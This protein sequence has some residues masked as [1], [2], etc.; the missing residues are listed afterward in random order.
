MMGLL[1]P[2][3]IAHGK[4][5]TSMPGNCVGFALDGRTLVTDSPDDDTALLWNLGTGKRIATVRHRNTAML[6]MR[7]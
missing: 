7:G 3:P 5:L 1:I 4:M 2:R 6:L